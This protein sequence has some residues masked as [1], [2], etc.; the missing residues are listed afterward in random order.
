MKL[1]IGLGILIIGVLLWQFGFFNRFNYLTAKIDIW[2]NTPRI[3]TAGIPEIPC[4]VPCIGLKEKYGFY[5]SNIGC[6][7]TE[8]QLRGINAYNNQIEKFL[9]KRN[10]KDWRK[11]Y[12][13][14]LGLL[15]N[16]GLLE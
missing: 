8:P 15:I 6:I 4:G 1:K 3:V 11:K 14:E 12:Q 9:N 2:S 7:V 13:M 16:Y 10:G 5:E